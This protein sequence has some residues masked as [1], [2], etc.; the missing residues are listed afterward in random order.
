M[1]FSPARLLPKFNDI[2]QWENTANSAYKGLSFTLKR[3]LANEI[4][5]SGSYT[6]SRTVDDASD[7][8]EQLQNPF[9]PRAGKALS[10]NDERHHFVLSGLFDLPFG[11]EEDGKKPS[12]L[13]ATLFGNIEVAPIVTI[14]SGRPLTPLIG[15]DADRNHAV[16]FSSRP[17]GLGR[18][19]LRTPAQVQ[20]DLRILKFFKVGEHGKLDFVAESFNLLNHTNVI[21]LNQFYGPGMS[22][23]PTFATP[24]KA[25]IP[26]QLQ[27]SVDFE[28]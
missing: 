25:G 11:D 10:L 4:E 24:N 7:F 28:F 20:V 6:I 15:F 13:V 22:P 21:A 19:S 9:L 14:G 17:L 8:D 26:R 27:F 18:N 2:Y 5:F 3:R 23:L 12:D 16:P 1:I